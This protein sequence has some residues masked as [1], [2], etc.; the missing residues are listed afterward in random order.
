MTACLFKWCKIM[1]EKW[2]N[3][4]EQTQKCHI[5]HWRNVSVL[6]FM[7]QM[8]HSLLTNRSGVLFI[9]EIQHRSKSC[10][11]LD[12]ANILKCLVPWQQFRE[13][14]GV[15]RFAKSLIKSLATF[16]KRNCLPSVIYT[17]GL[18]YRHWGQSG[19]LYDCPESVN[20]LVPLMQLLWNIFWCSGLS[21][22][23]G[24]GRKCSTDQHQNSH[25]SEIL[26]KQFM[27][28]AFPKYSER[29]KALTVTIRVS[30]SWF[31]NSAGIHFAWNKYRFSN[32]NEAHARE[33]TDTFT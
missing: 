26:Q 12:L 24:F 22:C 18:Y 3:Q 9:F 29:G 27:R 10:C 6:S 14:V 21:S 5:S 33:L 8:S 11:S 31:S 19:I 32:G 4:L 28:F 1:S 23:L 16:K 20:M 30:G 13:H 7:N 25:S 17:V 2:I 15:N